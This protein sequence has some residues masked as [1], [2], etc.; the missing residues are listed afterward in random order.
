MFSQ[1]L[2]NVISHCHAARSR[3]IQT[4]Q[5][6]DG[7]CDSVTPRKMTGGPADSGSG[8]D[9]T[10][11]QRTSHQPGPEGE[12]AY[13]CRGRVHHRQQAPDD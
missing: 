1:R 9:Q 3:S 8:P 6:I 12:L 2:G 7:T 10:G 5:T 4:G 11:C 13:P